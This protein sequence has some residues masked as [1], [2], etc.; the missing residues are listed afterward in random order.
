MPMKRSHDMQAVLTCHMMSWMHEQDGA[1]VL[2]GRDHYCHEHHVVKQLCANGSI[3]LRTVLS[4]N[5]GAKHHQNN[6]PI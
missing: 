3:H 2:Y 6:R 5:I 1:V 4:C